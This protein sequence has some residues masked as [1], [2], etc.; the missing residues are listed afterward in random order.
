MAR[1]PVE[2]TH[3][4][5]NVPLPVRMR[6]ARP[7]SEDDLMAFCAAN[8][9]M[10]VERE[11]DGTI[12]MTPAGYGSNRREN[13]VGRELD[14]WA[15]HDGRGEAF[16]SNAG[17]SLADGSTLSPDAGWISSKRLEGVTAAERERYLPRCPEF[18]VEVLSG[19]DSLSDA[20]EKMR[21]WLMNGVELG[22]LIDPYAAAVS[23]FRP[24]S[25]MERVYRPERMLG[26]GP[27]EGF[28]LKM[29]RLWA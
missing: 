22:W 26:E 19:S 4:I 24:G 28:E 23:V 20:E 27:V 21:R 5:S 16:G 2:M 18:V 11:S 17:F 12:V 25:E 13:Y 3:T 14:L 8:E 6:P 15:E 10:R 7:W 1:E 9:G 29:E